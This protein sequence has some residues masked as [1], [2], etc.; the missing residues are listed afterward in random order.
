MYLNNNTPLVAVDINSTSV[1]VARISF[2]KNQH[3]LMNLSVTPLSKGT[4]VDE[5]IEKPDEVVN[6]LKRLVEKE[7][8]KY[9]HAIVSVPGNSAV[10]RKIQMPKMSHEKLYEKILDEI[11]DH[12]PFE[13]NNV[14]IDFKVISSNQNGNIDQEYVDWKNK[15]N[16]DKPIGSNID[17]HIAQNEKQ[18][19]LITAIPKDY[20]E[21]RLDILAEVGLEPVIVDLDIFALINTLS[22]TK[23]FSLKDPVALIYLNE[24]QTHI[25]IIE[26]GLP[27]FIDDIPIIRNCDTVWT[28]KSPKVSF[29]STE[30]R[31]LLKL[32]N[33]HET[34]Q[35][36]TKKVDW[37]KSLVSKDNKVLPFN[38][39][40][41]EI[42]VA[43]QIF[44][45]HKNKQV[46]QI[47][48][49]GAGALFSGAEALLYDCF[50]IPVK[51]INPF[52]SINIRESH[53]DKETTNSFGPLS[54]VLTG[55]AIRRFDYK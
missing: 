26:N 42:K 37:E 22:F 6:A 32:F 33:N 16:N 43:L 52:L 46:K 15:F 13:K 38:K 10:I 17:P 27:A 9:K 54:S 23:G 40:I 25:N 8:L 31:G 12:I 45:D 14:K 39:V 53:F 11:E 48:I 28:K 1:A 51:T 41:E 34:Q 49:C 44:S 2:I 36:L 4:V 5:A 55:L 21:D 35:P 29:D 3:E 19:V 47:Y 30:K 20:V 18:E 50:K 7:K 24:P